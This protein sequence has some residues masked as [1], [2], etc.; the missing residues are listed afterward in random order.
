[1]KPKTDK[2]MTKVYFFTLNNR[3]KYKKEKDK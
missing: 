3:I 1:M 2:H